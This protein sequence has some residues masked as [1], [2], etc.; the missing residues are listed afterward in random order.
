[1]LDYD[2]EAAR[3]DDTRGG[4]ARAEAAADAIASLL[5]AVR[6]RTVLDVAGGTGLVASRL[7]RRGY[8]AVVCD[9]SAGMLALAAGRWPGRTLRGDATRL[10][11]A[12]GRVDAVVV[13]WLLHLLASPV[14][15]A[16]VVSEAA[17][18]LRP[19]GM[20]VSTV[21]KD[22]GHPPDTDVERL[23][24]SYGRT[25]GGAAPTDARGQVEVLARKA[26]LTLQAEGGFVGHGQGRVPAALADVLESSSRSYQHV[27]PRRKEALIRDLRALPDPDLARTPP[28]Y[29]LLAWQKAA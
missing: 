4:V 27:E 26:G 14:E 18:V 12:T 13:V 23:L 24:V 2:V 17:R 6:A 21:D 16:A 9:R 20:L 8:D 10:P 3:Y 1:M 29:R 25:Q 22:A 11:F 5:R 7:A 28:T 15:V 19:G